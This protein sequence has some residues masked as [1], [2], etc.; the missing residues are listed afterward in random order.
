MRFRSAMV[1]G[2]LA[3]LLSLV[4]SQTPAESHDTVARLTGNG[5]ILMVRHALAPGNG[6]PPEFRLGECATQRNL[7]E[8]GRE[9]AR[10]IGHWLRANGVFAAR[11]YS[12]QWCRCRE[13][14]ELMNVG[15]VTPLPA[16]NSF[17]DRPTM[18]EPTLEALRDFLAT[19][20][21]DEPLT[22]LVTH[23]VVIAAMTGLGV[24]SGEGVLVERA[25]PGRVVVRARL[26]FWD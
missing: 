5:H 23:H 19:R 15:E 7:D 9:Q 18:R 11:V 14:A 24:A 25:A 13:T 17:Y 12:S 6:D 1:N 10:A 16:L 26:R 3:S 8:R 20:T 2:V 21:D 22:I 4:A